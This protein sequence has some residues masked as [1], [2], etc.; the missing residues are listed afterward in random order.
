MAGER[1]RRPRKPAVREPRSGLPWPRERIFRRNAY[2]CW[3]AS[4]LDRAYT[5][6]L[7]VGLL[8]IQ[9]ELPR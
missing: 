4:G 2:G 8:R 3:T 5:T 9:V 1:S 6:Y 7:I